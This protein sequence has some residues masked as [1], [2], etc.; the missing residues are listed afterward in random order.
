MAALPSPAPAKSWAERVHEHHVR[1]GIVLGNCEA[2]RKG[3]DRPEWVKRAE[4]RR[5]PVKVYAP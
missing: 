2:C 1:L 5:L 3:D 4:E